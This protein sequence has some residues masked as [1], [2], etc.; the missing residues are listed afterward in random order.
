[1]SECVC[2]HA[3]VYSIPSPYIFMILSIHFLISMFNHYD[4]HLPDRESEVGPIQVYDDPI[5][6]KLFPR[7]AEGGKTD[8][9]LP[10]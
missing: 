8:Q 3:C 6:G 10:T 7:R 2:V 5:Q 1:M 4:F 9:G